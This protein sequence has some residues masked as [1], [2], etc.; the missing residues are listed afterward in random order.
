LGAPRPIIT[1]RYG[2]DELQHAFEVFFGR[3]TGKVVIER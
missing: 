1:H 3:E 2:I